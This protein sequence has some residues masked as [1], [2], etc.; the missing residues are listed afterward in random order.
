MFILNVILLFHNSVH[1]FPVFFFQFSWA[2]RWIQQS[3]ETI[4]N[5]E[6][7]FFYFDFLP[8]FTFWKLCYFIFSHQS[9]KQYFVLLFNF[10]SHTHTKNNTLYILNEYDLIQNTM[11]SSYCHVWVLN[12]HW[13]KLTFNA[14]KGIEP[15]QND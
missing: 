7:F 4:D 5:W 12:V 6:Y 1:R 13:Q 3:R 10:L 8:V 2:V 9:E 15:S 14:D 11:F